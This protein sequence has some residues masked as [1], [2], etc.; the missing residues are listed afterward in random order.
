MI[1][2]A[3]RY[4]TKIVVEKVVENL[5]EV[6]CSVLVLSISRSKYHRRSLVQ[7]NFQRMLINT[8]EKEKL[9]VIILKEW[10]QL[11]ELC[12]QEL[13]MIYIMKFKRLHKNI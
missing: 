9:K 3:T 8:L 12:Q 5:V 7:M 4:D 13:I 10:L 11:I 1:N 6:N 2:E